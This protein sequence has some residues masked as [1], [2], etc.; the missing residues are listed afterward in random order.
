MSAGNRLP[1]LNVK[2]FTDNIVVVYEDII[3]GQ[4]FNL[5]HLCEMLSD[6]Q[7]AMACR[8][9]FIRG[10]IAFGTIS[11][12]ESIVFGDALIK[13]HE[14]EKKYARNPRIILDCDLTA[15]VTKNIPTLPDID[16]NTWRFRVMRDVDGF[17]FVNYLAESIQAKSPFDR[18]RTIDDN[19]ISEHRS[20]IEHNLNTY[21]NRPDIWSKYF[22]SANYH[23]AFCDQQRAT[24]HKISTD[25]LSVQPVT[26]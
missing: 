4:L 5:C 13:A 18:L 19:I 14:L 8:G 20:Q 23:N 25:L 11:I 24:D 6:L 10:G 21:R 16:K 22:W 15:D 3:Q 17:Y 12:S 1:R 9:Y 7:L 2:M 26:V